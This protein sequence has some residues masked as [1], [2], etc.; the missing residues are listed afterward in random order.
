MHLLQNYPD[1]FDILTW[2][3]I[4][5]K[6]KRKRGYD[7]VA[8]IAEAV[9]AELQQTPVATLKKVKDVKPQST[10]KDPAH[11]RANILG[12]FRCISPEA[13]AGKR[14]LLLDDIITTGSTVSE[15]ARILLTAGA[16]EVWPRDSVHARKRSCDGCGCGNS[17]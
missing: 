10:M 7:Q 14:V 16:K 9:G 1:G 12:A 4:G 8:L 13:V 3:P 5:A 6:R 11:R 15:C 2:V 17:E